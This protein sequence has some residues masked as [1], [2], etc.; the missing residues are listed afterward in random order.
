MKK[1]LLPQILLLA[2]LSSF[3]A[4]SPAVKAPT[5]FF[6]MAGN[7]CSSVRKALDNDASSRRLR[8]SQLDLMV[9][10]GKISSYGAELTRLEYNTL[11]QLYYTSAEYISETNEALEDYKTPADE[12]VTLK[13]KN[14]MLLL[15]NK[16]EQ[17]SKNEVINEVD[18]ILD[19][20][21]FLDNEIELK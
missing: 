15:A 6:D 11:Y 19:R 5:N 8:D 13:T 4:C 12:I 2:I 9:T 14:N 1:L 3:F 17:E 10:N 16:D 20:I 7:E 18:S 21:Q